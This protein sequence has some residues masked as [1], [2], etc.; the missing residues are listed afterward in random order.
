[1]IL[2]LSQNNK[3]KHIITK[4]AVKSTNNKVKKQ[5]KAKKWK[6]DIDSKCYIWYIWYALE[7]SVENTRKKHKKS[8]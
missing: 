3:N 7:K 1:M 2:F 8:Q 5:K 4:K 6:K